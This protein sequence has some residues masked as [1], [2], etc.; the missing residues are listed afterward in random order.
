MTVAFRVA[1]KNPNSQ[2]VFGELQSIAVN[3]NINVSVPLNHYDRAGIVI[4]SVDGHELPSSINQFDQPKQCSMTTDQSR[5]TGTLGL[6]LS[7]HA[8]S[9]TTS[10]GVFG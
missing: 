1:H 4:V 3:K 5:T 2:P 6:R 8:I 10:G 9:C 7:T